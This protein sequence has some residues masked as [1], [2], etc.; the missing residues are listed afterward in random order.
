MTPTTD[1]RKPLDLLLH[2]PSEEEE[3]EGLLGAGVD[4]EEEEEG[5]TESERGEE[6][7][8]DRLPKSVTAFY[9]QM[10][11]G[12]SIQEMHIDALIHKLL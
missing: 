7:R 3:E 10:I 5:E 1:L 6:R 12:I 11:A 8:E 2:L 9:S 4:E